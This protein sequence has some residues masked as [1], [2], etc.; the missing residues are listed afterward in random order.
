L[1]IKLPLCLRILVVVKLKD[2]FI[3]RMIVQ[4]MTVLFFFK[5]NDFFEKVF[6]MKL[7]IE[8]LFIV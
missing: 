8:H 6:K 4:N 1:N 5:V 3:M 2:D 7:L